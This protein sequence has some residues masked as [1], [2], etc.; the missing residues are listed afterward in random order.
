MVGLGPE[1]RRSRMADIASSVAASTARPQADVAG[2]GAGVGV[3][4]GAGVGVGVEV[5]LLG[6]QL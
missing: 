6:Y 2:M 3:G 4:A 5:G 1:V